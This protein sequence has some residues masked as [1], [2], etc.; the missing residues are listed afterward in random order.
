MSVLDRISNLD[1]RII[2]LAVAAG[3]DHSAAASRSGSRWTS[4]SPS[5]RSTT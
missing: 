1:R 5:R 2:F 3:G 4:A